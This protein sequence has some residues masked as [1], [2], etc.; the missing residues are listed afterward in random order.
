MD[1]DQA[2]VGE[3]VG[4][5]DDVNEIVRRE[6][7]AGVIGDDND[8]LLPGSLD[9]FSLV[10]LVMALEEKFGVALGPEDLSA[11]ELSSI[12]GIQRVVQKAVESSRNG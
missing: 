7:P 4:S 12:S 1:N 3:A 8:S 10:K 11:E 9:S 5:F 2:L 6:L